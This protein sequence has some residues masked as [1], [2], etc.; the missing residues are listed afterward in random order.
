MMGL[1][2]YQDY[3]RI[4]IYGFDMGAQDEFIPQ[5]ACAEF[6]MGLALGLGKEIYMPPNCQLCWAPL[7]GYQ[8]TGARNVIGGPLD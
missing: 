8:G 2:L 7:Y 4:E 5:K 1:A 3:D 6:W